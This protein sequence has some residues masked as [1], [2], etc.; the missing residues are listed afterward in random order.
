MEGRAAG[1]RR[2]IQIARKDIPAC[3]ADERLGEVHD[4]VRAAGHSQCI[5]V[6]EDR[7][8]FGRLRSKAWE[9]DPNATVEEVMELGPATIRPDVF[10]HDIVERLRKRQA[11]S[12]LVTSYG[13]HEGGRLLGVL[14]REDIERVLAEIE[15]AK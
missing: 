1:R 2:A 13:S 7:V 4:R 6:N 12:I 14:F 3:R 8:V 11:G 5:V 15:H 9:N 10:L